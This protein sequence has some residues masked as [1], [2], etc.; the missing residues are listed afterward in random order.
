[1][2]LQ[3]LLLLFC[4]HSAKRRLS[5]RHFRSCNLIKFGRLHILWATH[6]VSHTAM[7]DVNG[8]FASTVGHRSLFSEGNGYGLDRIIGVLFE[9]GR[10][11]KQL[12]P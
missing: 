5:L 7:R 12:W 4:K 10:G 11:V 2:E 9:A 3:N 1:M 6:F 8:L